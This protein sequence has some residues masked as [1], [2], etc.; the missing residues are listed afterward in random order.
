M[1]DDLTERARGRIGQVVNGK[2]RIDALLGVGSTAAVFAT[3][4]R[5]GHRA[6]LKML[7]RE[8]SKRDAHPYETLA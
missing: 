1:E 8:Y 6:A 7:H 4:H 2:Y 3:T 5:N